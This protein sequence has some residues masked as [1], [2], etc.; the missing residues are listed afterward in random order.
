M[1]KR[2]LLFF[3]V[4][5]IF[6]GAVSS[7]NVPDQE[8]NKVAEHIQKLIKRDSINNRIIEELKG[9]IDSLKGKKP[10]KSSQETDLGSWGD[11]P[12]AMEKLGPFK[13]RGTGAGE[14]SLI[15]FMMVAFGA[16]LIALVTPCVFP[17]IPMTVTFFTNAS[18]SRGQAVRKA[19]VYGF[20][21]IAI[22]SLIGLVLSKLNGADFASFLSTHWLPNV[23]FF[24]IFLVFA[25][26]FLGMFEINLPT[27]FVNK[28]DQEADKGGY[29]GV[30][31]MAFTL[32]LVSFSCTGPI[33]GS[34]LVE[35][36]GGQTLKPFL[37]MLAY[38]SAFAIPFTLFAMFPSWLSRLPKSGGWL[39]VVKVTLGFLELALAFKFLSVADQ[40][41]H[42]NILG[43]DVFIAIWIVIFVLLG[44]YLLGKIRMPHD[45]PVENTSVPRLILAIIS[46]SFA[47]YLFP[48]LFGA[49]L[50]AISGYLPPMYTHDFD[51]PGIIRTYTSDKHSAGKVLCEEPKYGSKLKLPHGLKGYFDYKQAIECAKEKGLPV[52][53]DFT[54]H[55]C[56]NCREMEANIWSDPEVL[57]RLSGDYLIVALYTDDRTIL[58]ETEWYKG[59]DGKTKKTIGAQNLDLEATKFKRNSQPF[60][61]LLD[62]YTEQLLA[63]PVGYTSSVAEFID[64]LEE[65]TTNF[66]IL[67]GKKK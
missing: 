57:R 53:I 13:D 33:V 1:F 30:V 45:S 20:S 46:F 23:I 21:I 36:A 50:K 38:S 61:V 26:S 37:G 39:N 27:K 22:Y 25:L 3:V 34:I 40:V 15:A 14:L 9:E 59:T 6:T 29:Y 52:F 66:E 10:L 55:G 41:Y 11:K 12:K 7:K 17:M 35:A 49:P 64:F 62:P 54:G 28:V 16:G 58:P 24:V 31:F 32:V 2:I 51:L 18:Q 4:L 43:R 63:E 60:Y 19:F 65:G 42:W 56:V 47:M 67:N 8:L 5:F 48:G 44:V